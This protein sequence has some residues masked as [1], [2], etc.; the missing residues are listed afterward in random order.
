MVRASLNITARFAKKFISYYGKYRINVD[1][2]NITL[3]QLHMITLSLT[4]CNERQ[5]RGRHWI[6]SIFNQQH[7]NHGLHH[8]DRIPT[9][10]FEKHFTQCSDVPI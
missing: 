7:T 9:R 6:R 10:I 1:L 3:C 4:V 5:Q 8:Q 2:L